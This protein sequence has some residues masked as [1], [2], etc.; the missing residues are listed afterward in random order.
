MPYKDPQKQKE[1]LARYFQENKERLRKAQNKKRGLLRRAIQEA[2]TDVPCADCKEVFPYYVMDFDHRPGVKK[3]FTIGTTS[4]A[5]SMEALIAEM[6]KC[7]IVCA[8]CHRHRTFI[9][10]GKRG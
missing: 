9:R 10:T 1:A 5:T 6:A 2:K 8:N 3:E 7:D 4:N